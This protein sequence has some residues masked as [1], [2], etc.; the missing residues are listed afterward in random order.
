L[1]KNIYRRLMM[2]M[3]IA[4]LTISG[5]A[6]N[7]QHPDKT[8]TEKWREDLRLMAEEVPKRHKDLFHQMTREQ[9]DTAIKNLET[10]IPN[11]KRNQ[12]IVEMARIVAMD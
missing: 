8:E 2:P 12:I 4:L 7:N 9:F 1:F 6:Q 5:L 3:L 10:S 11:L